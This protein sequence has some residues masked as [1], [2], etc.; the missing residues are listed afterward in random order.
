MKDTEWDRNISRS[1][2]SNYLLSHGT[3]GS[4]DHPYRAPQKSSPSI[5]YSRERQQNENP[6]FTSSHGMFTP[7]TGRV[8]W[9]SSRPFQIG[10]PSNRPGGTSRDSLSYSRMKLLEIYRKTDVNNFVI[11]VPDIEKTSLLWQADPAE[12]LALTVPS[13]EE[14]VS[15]SMCS[16]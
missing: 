1:W 5:G 13:A 6:N 9:A 10:I 2:N 16:S 3:G 12:L 7:S 15:F 11:P 8:S 14:V 4:Y